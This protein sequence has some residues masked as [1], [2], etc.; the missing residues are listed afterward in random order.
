MTP[1]L[2]HAHASPKQPSPQ[3]TVHYNNDNQ[4]RIPP[5]KTPLTIIHH[6]VTSPY[7][8]QSPRPPSPPQIRPKPLSQNNIPRPT[9]IPPH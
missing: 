3:P 7:P 4:T 2:T 9:T 1:A 8:I 6:A 5:T